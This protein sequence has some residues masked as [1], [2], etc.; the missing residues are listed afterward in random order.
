MSL[1]VKLMWAFVGVA[2][3]ALLLSFL[4]LNF[5]MYA[6]MGMDG[7]VGHMVGA[8]AI[9]FTLRTSLWASVAA[10]VVAAGVGLWMAGRMTGPLRQL[11]HA[12]SLVDL[13]DLSRRVPVQGADEIAD[14]A[15]TFNR[16]GERLETEERVRRQLL[17]DVAHELRHPLAVVQGHLDL[18]QDGKMP[19]E[20]EALLPIADEMIRLR[21]LVGDL[22]DLSLADVGALT[23]DPSD[24]DVAALV[25]TLIGNMEPVAAA[26]D[27]QLEV[28][29]AAGLPPVRAD[30]DRLRQ[31]FVNL[32]SN[33]LRF[34]PAG[35]RVLVKVQSVPEGVQV[36][37]QDT[38]SGIAPE[39]L[40]HIFDR[41]YRGDKSRS[42]ESG[43]SGLGLAIVRGLV[44]AH[45]GTVAVQSQAGRG[46]CFTV[47]IP[48]APG[49]GR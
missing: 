11:G 4:G 5:G 47:T 10:L 7:H 44:Q 15:R 16:M 28:E 30:L 17:A 2:F 29:L 3:T 46:S 36:H 37:F 43:G 41:F 21:R 25:S 40:P 8:E 48:A 1:R 6:M 26:R 32:L 31:V 9:G 18:I 34:T 14:L 22:R 23:L 13:R 33:A 20:L 45:H 39:D 35:G 49:G 12:V 27:V 19:L 38:G 42:R 24:V